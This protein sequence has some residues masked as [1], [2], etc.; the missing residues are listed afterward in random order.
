MLAA[1]AVNG[2]CFVPCRAKQLFTVAPAAE[3]AL[4]FG[5]LGI[6]GKFVAYEDSSGESTVC[7]VVN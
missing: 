6:R 5:W 7:S 2:D 1:G 3:S 4:I